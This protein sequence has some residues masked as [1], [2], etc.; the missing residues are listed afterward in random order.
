MTDAPATATVTASTPAAPASPAASSPAGGSTPARETIS[1]A[2]FSRLP[3]E[4][5]AQYA[6]IGRPD[7]S[8]PAEWV[9]RTDLAAHP[10]KPAATAA[11]TEAATAPVAEATATK[12]TAEQYK[13]EHSKG[14]K[15][16]EGAQYAIQPSAP[17]AA[18]ARNFAAK[19]GLSQE[20]FSEL[21]DLY[22]AGQKN[23]IAA[24]NQAAAAELAK[25][26]ANGAARISA[27]K[28]FFGGL[29]GEAAA[30][31][32]SGMMVTASSARA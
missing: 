16:P 12:L 19:H 8:G 13:L 28:G 4:Q 14:F 6:N 30:K 18:E 29:V 11:T 22:V 20:G 25:V 24:L 23:D 3:A 7:R 21:I 31:Q 2:A 15:P 10:A 32:L 5:Q 17:L 9:K 26:G 1:E 27:L